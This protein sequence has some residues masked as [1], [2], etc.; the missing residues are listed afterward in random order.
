MF[1]NRLITFLA[2]RVRDG[3]RRTARPNALTPA[4]VVEYPDALQV[5]ILFS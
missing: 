1:T 2:D 4:Q 3:N 5:P